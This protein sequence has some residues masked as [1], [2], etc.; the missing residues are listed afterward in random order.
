ISQRA[1]QTRRILYGGSLV[2]SVWVGYSEGAVKQ[3]VGAL[4]VGPAT[5]TL[6]SPTTDPGALIGAT[7]TKLDA[8]LSW[9]WGSTY[10]S[11]SAWRSQ[12]VSNLSVASVADG[13]D[14]SLGVLEKN[15]SANAYM[16]LSRWN[17]QDGV[18]YSGNYNLGGG[19]SFS[20]LLENYPNVTLSFDVSNYSD[21]YTAW[22]QRDNGRTTSAGIA[23]DF[24]K[25]LIESR[26]Q[27]LKFFYSAQNG[28]YGSQWGVVNSYSRTIGHVFG[29]V[30][31][32]SL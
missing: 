23:F 29:T 7:I 1:S 28:G 16:S 12:Q 32:T 15:W 17:S 9:Q 25:Y 3:S 11:V 6:V 4:T 18:N 14:A 5:V 2:P 19:A 31:R 30:F 13:G 24:S 21:A 10:A 22:D 26:G 20:V 27:K 8:G